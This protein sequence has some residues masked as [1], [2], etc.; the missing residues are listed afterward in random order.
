M[1]SLRVLQELASAGAY[2][3]NHVWMLWLHSPAAKQRLVE[4]KDLRVKG[5]RCLVFDPV[6]MK[7]RVKLHWVPYHVPN[8]QVRKELERFGK[9][10]DI[11]RDH[12]RE[13][14]FENVQTNTRIVRM[15][16]KDGINV[17]DMTQEIRV[18]GCKVLV[19][20]PG[21]APLCLRCRR[22]GH[23]RRACCVPQCTECHQL[24]LKGTDF[25]HERK[26]L[27]ANDWQMDEAEADAATGEMGP[28]TSK[29]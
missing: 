9:V 7:V 1:E 8:C 28:Q 15:K 23:I 20:V 13:N 6:S 29:K 25:A 10:A 4:A 22:K 18:E 12:F 24:G 21:R 16:L 11:S 19:L 14:G 2:Q 3:M 27:E 17:D 26:D 5:G